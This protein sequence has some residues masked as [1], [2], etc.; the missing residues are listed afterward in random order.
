MTQ[1][2]LLDAPLS[3]RDRVAC[4]LKARPCEWI[5]LIEL[6]RVGGFYAARTRVS[7]CRTQLGMVI[8]NRLRKDGRRTVS[9]YRFVEGPCQ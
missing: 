7:D 8:E 2:S 6:M 4:Y 9:E 3:Y 5:D 1:L